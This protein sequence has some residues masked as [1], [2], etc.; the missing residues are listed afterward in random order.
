M[1]GKRL[2]MWCS[3]IV[4]VGAVLWFRSEA[5]QDTSPAD[6]PL[7]KTRIVF[8]TGGA[9]DFWKLTV[10]GAE[11]AAH[12]HNAELD[13]KLLEQGEAL[14]QQ[15]EILIN[16]N[17][18]KVD[19]CAVSPLDASGQTLLI[20]R[21]AD[22]M[23]VVTFDSDA[24]LSQRHYY[25]G[26]SNYRAGQICCELVEEALPDGGKVAVLLSNLTKNNMIERK[27]GYEE[28]VDG[29]KW[30]TV[31]YL[32][33]DGNAENAKANMQKVLEE[34][35]GLSCIV[36]MNGYHGPLLREVL[37]ETG[38][39][40][41]VTLVTFDWAPETLAGIEKDEIYATVAQDP[42]KYGYEAVRMLTSL[43]NGMSRELPI[44]G[45]GQINVNCEP[46]RKDD[47]S[48]FRKKIRSQQNE[49]ANGEKK[50]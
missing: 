35:E 49:N 50:S 39:L 42:Y 1:P 20:N 28:K 10:K 13:I 37:A 5:M 25:I 47:L 33:D 6:G 29:E 30:E 9:D 36:G 26:T 41:K 34:T 8:V 12:E 31:D 27:A 43:H 17:N 40:G 32:T 11:A 19:G 24:P 44:V 18:T 2:W 22:K 14:A 48:Q 45:G 7:A 38:H 3:L 21:L 15:M 46:L 16:L 23:K 4:A